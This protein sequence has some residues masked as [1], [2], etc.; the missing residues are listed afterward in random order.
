M[1]IANKPIKATIIFNTGGKFEPV[2]FVVDDKTVIVEKI[3][4]TKEEN[5]AGNKR[6]VFVCQHSGK[7]I[8]ELKYEIYSGIWYL[9]KK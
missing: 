3:L 4:E 8:F 2:K 6:I 7:F 9:F 1:K 5:L